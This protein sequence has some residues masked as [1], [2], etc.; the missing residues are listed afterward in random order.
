MNFTKI[1][2]FLMI[3]ALCLACNPVDAA[4]MGNRRVAKMQQNF[5]Q[6]KMAKMFMRR[7]KHANK[8]FF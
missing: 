8:L 7:R 3:L 6:Q 5:L 4:R 2:S 1:A